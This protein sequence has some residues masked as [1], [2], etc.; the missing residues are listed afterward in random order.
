[1]P[2]VTKP[3]PGEPY[4]TIYETITLGGCSISR[5]GSGALAQISDSRP[6]KN[7]LWAEAAERWAQPLRVVACIAAVHN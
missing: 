7:T 3:Y 4:E 2:H 5:L 1:M 6:E